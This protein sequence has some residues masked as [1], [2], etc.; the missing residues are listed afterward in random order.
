MTQAHYSLHHWIGLCIYTCNTCS[1]IRV[2]GHREYLFFINVN[3]S[4]TKM[5]GFWQKF[6][7]SHQC[8]MYR[9]YKGVRVRVMMFNAT[10]NNISVISW[11]RVL[12][13]EETGV[14]R[15]IHRPVASHWQTLSHNVISS[16]PCQEQLVVIGTNC[17]DNCKSNYHTITTT[18]TPL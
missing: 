7:I 6:R 13:V 15:E 4:V 3:N 11:R 5:S 8:Y 16:T 14:P 12:L 2:G 1:T 10:F 17:T 18:T 9:D